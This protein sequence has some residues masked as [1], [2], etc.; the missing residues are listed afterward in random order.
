MIKWYRAKFE[1]ELD[2]I[3]QD[4]IDLLSHTLIVNSTQADANLV[5][6]G[7]QRSQSK[8][9]AETEAHRKNIDIKKSQIDQK[10]REILQIMDENEEGADVFA[11]HPTTPA[12]ICFFCFVLPF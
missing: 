4:V 7:R 11:A 1:D 2:K 8:M 3:C 10:K 9:A 5:Q 6:D 12:T